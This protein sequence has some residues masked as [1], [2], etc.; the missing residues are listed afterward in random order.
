[1]LRRTMLWA[2]IYRF[3]DDFTFNQLYLFLYLVAKFNSILLLKGA[4]NSLFSNWLWYWSKNILLRNSPFVST[5]TYFQ[6]QKFIS[7]LAEANESNAM[8]ERQKAQNY[9]P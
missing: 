1:M 3:N 7:I 6:Y 2:M 5:S 8:K 4:L 9:L